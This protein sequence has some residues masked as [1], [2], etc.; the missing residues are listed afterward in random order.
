MKIYLLNT[1]EQGKLVSRDMAGGLGFDRTE[2]N[3][4]P[5]LDLLWLATALQEA[6]HGVR[7]LDP[8][9]EPGEPAE[10]LQEIHDFGP[11]AVVMTLSLPSLEL[12]A[13]FCR[14]LRERLPQCTLVLKTGIRHDPILVQALELSSADFCLFGECD[15][16][17]AQVLS[18]ESTEGTARLVDGKLTITEEK[19]LE[20]LDRLPIPD[21]RL[22]LNERYAYSRLGSHLTTMQTSRGC[23]Y[24]CGYYCPYPLVQGKKWR[25]M[26]IDRVLAELESICRLNIP[27][28][29]FRDATLTLNRQRA[30]TM[31]QEIVA[32]GLRFQ[33]WCETRIDCLD[34]ELL[35]AMQRAG[36]IGI[37]IGVESGDEE[38]LKLHAR[39]GVQPTHIE[40]LTTYCKKIGIRLHYLLLVGLP[41]ETRDSLYET[42][43]LVDDLNPE[44][45][46]VTTATPYPGT[47]LYEDAVREQWIVDP[48]PNSFGGHGYNM[49]IKGLAADDL[50]FALERIHEVCRLNQLPEQAGSERRAEI[51]Q[52][53]AAWRS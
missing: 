50:R 27:A 22:L 39:K 19:R 44:S 38:M 18:G 30:L 12:D 41:G 20:E 46:G 33:W 17:I 7:L 40:R 35:D 53:F 49:E 31:C 48:D 8:Q 2:R 11:D 34:E 5:P 26:S 32:R 45:V 37:N 51:H 28:V 25:A 3:L 47:Q 52:E 42:F 1:P 4:L 21:R 10:I 14:Q 24:K 16:I 13:R 9:V 15:L 6:G 36:C 43:R 29:L 23:P